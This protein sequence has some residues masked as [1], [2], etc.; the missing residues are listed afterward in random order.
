MNDINA[1]LAF[2]K[3]HIW[4]PYSSMNSNQIILPVLCA[5]GCKLTL[6]D[7]QETQLI[8]GIS[9]WWCMIHGYSDERMNEALKTQI[10][11]FSHVMFLSL[12][13]I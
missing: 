9:S 10:D 2:D 7:E 1:L 5:K 4:H 8:D 11:D 6:A 12:I 13:H 3:A